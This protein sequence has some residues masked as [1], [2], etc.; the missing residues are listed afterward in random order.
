MAVDDPRPH[1]QVVADFVRANPAGVTLRQIREELVAHGR[2]AS[3][4]FPDAT[5]LSVNEP[6]RVHYAGGKEVRRTDTHNRYDILFRRP[7]RSYVLYDPAVHGVWEVAKGSDGKT[8]QVRLVAEPAETTEDGDAPDDAATTQVP[9][10]DD[11]ASS[12]FRLES[13]LRDYLA[14]NLSVF[15]SL[16]T[17]LSLYEEDN[18][19]RG[20]EYPTDVGPIDIL[21]VGQDGAYYVI[22]LK[23]SR[24]ADAAVGQ[25]LRYMGA[26][27]KSIAA[28]K[29]VYGVIVAASFT[30]R[31]RAALSEVR[32]RVFALEYELK[33]SVRPIAP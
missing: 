26:V 25:V 22:E 33:V 24:G 18:E 28:G 14:Q 32:D 21:A 23:V 16:G 30:D 9:G 3:N 13:H 11:E 2:K 29:P 10:T 5:S 20:V 8:R 15:T 31:I 17:S 27:R 12:Q 1:W 19:P 4:A 7:D 6:S